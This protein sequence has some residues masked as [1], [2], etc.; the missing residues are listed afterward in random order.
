MAAERAE[1]R[2]TGMNPERWHQLEQIYNSVLECNPE[3]RNAFLVEACA[4]D[5]ALRKEVESL[6]ACNDEADPLGNTSAMR[7]W[8]FS[9]SPD[10]RWLLYAQFEPR[11]SDLLVVEN[12]H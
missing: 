4:G 11:G 12:F 6:L 7:T 5:E 1:G 10:G 9:V 3:E 8:G 2:R